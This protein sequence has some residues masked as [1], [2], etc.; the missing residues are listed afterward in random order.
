MNALFCSLTTAAACGW[1]GSSCWNSH[2]I[3]DLLFWSTLRNVVPLGLQFLPRHRCPCAGQQAKPLAIPQC[4][5]AQ[6][7][8]LSQLLWTISRAFLHRLYLACCDGPPGAGV[9]GLFLCCLYNELSEGYSS[10]AMCRIYW[11]SRFSL[12]MTSHRKAGSFRISPLPFHYPLSQWAA[13]QEK[14]TL[15]NQSSGPGLTPI[16][17]RWNTEVTCY[18]IQG[19]GVDCSPSLCLTVSFYQY[20]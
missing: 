13:P 15:E 9:R 20:L 1:S 17:L 18:L 8:S 14:N 2:R 16:H 19:E 6:L 5:L 4:S 10:V 12:P 11:C 3:L 7:L